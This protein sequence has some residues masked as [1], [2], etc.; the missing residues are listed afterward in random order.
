[1]RFKKLKFIT[2][3]LMGATYVLTGF[4]F[5]SFSKTTISSYGYH[6]P[7]LTL[8]PM[9][10]LVSFCSTETPLSSSDLILEVLPYIISDQ[11]SIAI[12]GKDASI[13]PDDIPK[14]K[15]MP[16]PLPDS[17]SNGTVTNES[18]GTVSSEDEKEITYNSRYIYCS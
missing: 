7:K 2:P 9:A 10:P 15:I 1:M 11:P 6:S 12:N 3:L 14:F 13:P 8:N 17:S 5:T 16:Y 4:C 18:R